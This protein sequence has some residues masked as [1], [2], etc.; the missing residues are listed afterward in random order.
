MRAVFRLRMTRLAVFAFASMAIAAAASLCGSNPP[1]W[2][3][4]FMLVQ[5]KVVDPGAEGGPNVNATTV[6]HYDW[7]RQVNL[8]QISPDGNN[9]DVLHDLE[10][11]T[12]KSFYFTP[13][14]R[15]CTPV[16]FSVGILRPDWLS[17]ATYLG[18]VR[19][20]AIG[21][22]V[23]AWTKADFIDYYADVETCE[24]VAW[25]FHSMR[26]WFH[27][28]L[29]VPDAQVP[30]LLWFEPPNYCSSSTNSTGS[31]NV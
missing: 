7:Q 24:P 19:P 30:D 22:P 10:L 20:A 17:N 25:Y 11:G 9:S 27:T 16:N 29:Y 1:L 6:T 18:V 12:G 21:R 31:I 3:E 28:V 15:A 13:T 2:P 26:A 8:I 14:R 23:R 4:Q 5:R